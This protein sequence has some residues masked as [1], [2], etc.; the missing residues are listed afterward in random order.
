[1]LTSLLATQWHALR[2]YRLSARLDKAHL[3]TLAVISLQLA[4]L[5]SGIE[6][7]HGAE[8]GEGTVF[9]HGNG[10]VI[11]TGAKVGRDCRL[12][13]QV[14]IGTQDG[15]T[16]PTLGDRVTCYPGAKIIGDITVGD[17][18]VIGANAVVL[19]DVAS[20]S[21]VAGNPAVVIRSRASD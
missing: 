1:V 2:L 14:T 10:I 17:D 13:H 15:H 4:K 18:A 5:I 20:G 7:D 19:N 3:P 12:F 9:I 8:I 21:V 16:Y 6:I 11:G